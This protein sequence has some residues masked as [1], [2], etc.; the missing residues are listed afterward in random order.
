ML[1]AAIVYAC[2]NIYKRY[3]SQYEAV[4]VREYDYGRTECVRAISTQ[5]Q[6]ALDSFKKQ[7]FL[8]ANKEHK[9]ELNRA[10]KDKA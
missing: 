7:D 5:L 1:Q 10:K 8:L 9:K 6:K 3:V 4:D 2:K